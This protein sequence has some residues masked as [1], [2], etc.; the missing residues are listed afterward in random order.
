MAIQ[1]RAVSCRGAW[2]D[3]RRLA[4]ALAVLHWRDICH[5]VPA[6]IALGLKVVKSAWLEG[7]LDGAG[8]GTNKLGD[9]TEFIT[10][11]RVR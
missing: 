7:L 9:V 11:L 4:R 1:G 3:G 6:A 8:V 2:A 10:L 5:P